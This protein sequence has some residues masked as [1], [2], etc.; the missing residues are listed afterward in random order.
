MGFTR[1]MQ[2]SYDVTNS[3]VRQY[4]RVYDFDLSLSA[5]DC[6]FLPLEGIFLALQHPK[7]RFVAA[8]L[9]MRQR[10]VIA[11][12]TKSPLPRILRH[13][14]GKYYVHL[15]F[16]APPTP[17]QPITGL[18]LWS[19]ATETFT[20]RVIVAEKTGTNFFLV[21]EGLKYTAEQRPPTDSNSWHFPMHWAGRDR[22]ETVCTRN[23]QLFATT[24]MQWMPQQGGAGEAPPIHSGDIGDGDREPRRARTNERDRDRDREGDRGRDRGRSDITTPLQPTPQPPPQPPPQPQEA[25]TLFAQRRQAAL[26]IPPPIMSRSLSP[27]RREHEE[28]D[29]PMVHFQG[30]GH[31]L[32]SS[33]NSQLAIRPLPNNPSN[34]IPEYDPAD[35]SLY[36]PSSDMNVVFDK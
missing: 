28:D 20:V 4:H 31:S 8:F 23:G 14:D 9:M 6:D 21:V 17:Q 36:Y 26:P 1:K 22:I 35:P 34:A 32:F 2:F 15:A 12:V 25:D 27:R 7:E 29:T 18:P 13:S 5:L 11:M 10:D 16:A 19:C 3:R 30:G 24:M 33:A